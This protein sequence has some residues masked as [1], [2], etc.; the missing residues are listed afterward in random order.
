MT[1]PID[2]MIVKTKMGSNLLLIHFVIFL[3][4]L[5]CLMTL[6]FLVRYSNIIL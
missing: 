2:T 3:L 5:L 6:A 1:G 4:E